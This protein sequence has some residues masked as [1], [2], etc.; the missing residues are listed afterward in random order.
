MAVRH[1]RRHGWK[2]LGRNVRPV[3]RDRRCEIDIV[4]RHAGE[5]I[6]AFV[7]VKT[8][9]RRSEFAP[10]LWAVDRRKKNV[11]LR[12]IRSWLRQHDYPGSWRFDVIE[13]YGS[14]RSGAAPEIDHI[15]YVRIKPA[16]RKPSF[17]R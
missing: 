9:L 13:V 15:E 2:I 11:L 8:H 1:L 4:C 16:R 14:C 17:Y 12:A 3:W 5:N 10:R 7:E 6:L